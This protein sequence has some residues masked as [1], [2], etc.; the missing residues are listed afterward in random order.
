MKFFSITLALASSTE[1]PLRG[2]ISIQ[3]EAS[4]I[5]NKWC[6]E[7]IWGGAN[8]V[9]NVVA[10]VYGGDQEGK[11]IAKS[12]IQAFIAVANPVVTF[13]NVAYGKDGQDNTL[14]DHIMTAI[15]TS[16]ERVHALL[17]K[18]DEDVTAIVKESMDAFLELAQSVVDIVNVFYDK[19]EIFDLTHSILDALKELNRDVF[20]QL[21]RHDKERSTWDVIS[22]MFKPAQDFGEETMRALEICF[23]WSPEFQHN[24][25]YLYLVNKFIN[26]LTFPSMFT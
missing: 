1:T 3:S 9:C 13:F 21:D 12:S 10:A 7:D 5:Q 11:K 4:R 6:L 25:W 26:A 17:D 20:R 24:N 2:L 8:A 16:S 18:K 14:T 22:K 15:E 19:P 23:D